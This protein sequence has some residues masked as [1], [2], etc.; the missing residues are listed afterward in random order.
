MLKCFIVPCIFAQA[1]EAFIY[2][3]CYIYIY[4]YIYME[5]VLGTC[6]LTNQGNWGDSVASKSS[7]H[8]V[9]LNYRT[10]IHHMV[11]RRTHDI[12]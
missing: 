2:I 8:Y 1:V 3:V 9:K 6:W 12:L 7:V 5:I 10:E 11:P 4:E